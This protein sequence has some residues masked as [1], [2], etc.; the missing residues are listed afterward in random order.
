VKAGDREKVKGIVR[1]VLD[2]EL[3]IRPPAFDPLP[4]IPVACATHLRRE[5]DELLDALGAYVP[6]HADALR[7]GD[8]MGGRRV[9][10]T[11]VT[12]DDRSQFPG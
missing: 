3:A 8:A 7:E 5:R 6:L 12:G 1:Q 2:V 11:S 9:M 10:Q 4:G